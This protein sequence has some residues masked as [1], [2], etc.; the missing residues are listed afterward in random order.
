MLLLIQI[1]TGTTSSKEHIIL[2]QD[3]QSSLSIIMLLVASEN[4]AGWPSI[5]VVDLTIGT[6]I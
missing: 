1:S 6:R 5:L 3:W 4:G 2:L